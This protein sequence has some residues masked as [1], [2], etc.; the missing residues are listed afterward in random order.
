MDALILLRNIVIGA[1]AL[2]LFF[3]L[4]CKIVGLARARKQRAYVLGTLFAPFMGIG[5]VRDPDHRLVN[6][7]TK[8]KE[9]EAD[10]S[11]DPLNREKSD[12][13]ES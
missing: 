13:P 3:V 12:L 7:A 10:D 8:Q 6:E 4:L 5:D 1:I 2:G 11:G 9:K